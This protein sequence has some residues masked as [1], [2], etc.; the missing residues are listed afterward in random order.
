MLDSWPRN[1]IF[2]GNDQVTFWLLIFYLSFTSIDNLGMIAIP[3]DPEASTVY[4]QY[5]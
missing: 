3:H 1:S 2:R 4:L 5:K